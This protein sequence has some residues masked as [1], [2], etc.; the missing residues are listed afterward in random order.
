LFFTLERL[1]QSFLSP[2]KQHISASYP[3]HTLSANRSI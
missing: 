3:K 2:S 1:S